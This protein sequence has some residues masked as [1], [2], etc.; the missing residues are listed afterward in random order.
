MAATDDDRKSSKASLR[1]QK[2]LA[3]LSS[4]DDDTRSRR[5]RK[6]CLNQLSAD[7]SEY[8]GYLR[9]LTDTFLSIFSPAECLEFMAASDT[10]RPTVIRTNTLK[11][12]PNALMTK[13]SKRGA[14]VEVMAPWSTV[15]LKVAASGVPLGATPEYLSGLYTLQSA[16]S[17][18]S[19]IALD[20]Q[21]GERVL[22][23][24][25]APGGKTSFICQLMENTGVV[26]SNDLKQ[27]RHKATVANLH[28]LGVKNTITTC[29]DGRQI[30]AVLGGFSRALLD[31]PCSG[32]G[33]ISRD[34]NIKS[35]RTL[36]DIRRLGRIQQELLLSAIDSVDETKSGV[37]VYSTCS[38]AIQE[39]E[40]VVQYALDTRYVKLV[41][42]GLEHA[43]PA[44]TRFQERRFHPMMYLA[45]RF[46]P[47][48]HNMDGF[49]V[50]KLV[51]FRKGARTSS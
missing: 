35:Q 18:C 33:V 14:V 43:K 22:D 42:T 4:P 13:L 5:S 6:E 17:M 15:G 45:S 12:D 48:I 25:A 10:A 1:I 32:L 19:V 27:H 47:H 16:S 24:A 23:L 46:Y 11:V 38:I 26:V 2:W 9:E 37:V 28:R 34:A 44:V 50:A 29:S 40:E 21:P 7:L 36:E 41:A 8:H 51:K 3:R 20:P 30:P 49:F 39:N 31:A